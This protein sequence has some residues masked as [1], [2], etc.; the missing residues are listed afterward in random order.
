MV[1][2]IQKGTGEGKFRMVIRSDRAPSWH[3]MENVWRVDELGAMNAQQACQASETNY[4]VRTAP[5]YVMDP[6]S[7]RLIEHSDDVAIVR[8]PLEG[9][10]AKVFGTAKKGWTPIQNIDIAKLLDA[11]LTDTWPVESMGAL[12]D[13]ETLFIAL[14]AGED[15]IAGERYHRYI[16]ITDGKAANRALTIAIT[17]VRYE[18]QNTV[19][20]GL[21]QASFTHKLRH[22]A[23]IAL[24]LED[25]LQMVRRIREGQGAVKEALQL[26]AQTRVTKPQK[27][28]IINYAYPIPKEPSHVRQAKEMGLEGLTP[29]RV[30]VAK[31]RIEKYEYWV[32]T[33]E[34]QRQMA[35]DRLTRF[36]DEFPQF[37]NT[38]YAVLQA[39]VENEDYRK[40]NRGNA[41]AA[42]SSIFGE[43]ASTKLRAYQKCADFAGAGSTPRSKRHAGDKA[44]SY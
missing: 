40:G 26:L 17:D 39:V 4:E 2:N 25:R 23:T 28:Q 5:V 20:L 8:Q 24:D 1:A 10:S 19:M 37:G 15:E 6:F 9:G 27:L 41:A 31:A 16:G 14:D 33:F 12:G 30:D 3:R 44:L 18:C 21:S 38:A 13:G 34:G 42:E 35:V 43:R 7:G 29:D 11:S 32:R 36:E 22:T